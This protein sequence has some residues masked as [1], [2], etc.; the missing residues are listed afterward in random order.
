[1]TPAQAVQENI[2]RALLDYPVAVRFIEY[3]GRRGAPD[4]MVFANGKVVALEVKAGKDRLSPVQREE[5]DYLQKIGIPVFVVTEK[6][7]HDICDNVLDILD[8]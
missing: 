3:R 2:R 7:V 5:L 4:V 8:V 1:M 6:N